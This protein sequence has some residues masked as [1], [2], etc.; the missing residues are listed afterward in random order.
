MDAWLFQD[1]NRRGLTWRL[2]K[3]Y[4]SWPM[5]MAGWCCVFTDGIG[6]QSALVIFNRMMRLPT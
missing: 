5:T 3:P 1:L 6:R 2:M 4:S